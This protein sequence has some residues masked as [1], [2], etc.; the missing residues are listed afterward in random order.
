MPIANYYYFIY[1]RWFGKPQKRNL[2]RKITT[3]K[4]K[5]MS[6]G[7]YISARCNKVCCHILKLFSCYI[8]ILKVCF[9]C[10]LPNNWKL[11]FSVRIAYQCIM[12]FVYMHVWVKVHWPQ[13]YILA[14]YTRRYDVSVCT[15]C[16]LGMCKK[17]VN[18]L[19]N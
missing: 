17:A 9:F 18:C 2:I 15:E 12:D 8:H 1:I 3:L 13:I 11:F 7:K 14:L 5:S 6:L 10:Q 16:P 19:T 4:T